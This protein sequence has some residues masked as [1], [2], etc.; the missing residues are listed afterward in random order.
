[1][2]LSPMLSPAGHPAL[3]GQGIG[4]AHT[5][6]AYR[7]MC[8]KESFLEH[9]GCETCLPPGLKR[10]PRGQ[11]PGWMKELGRGLTPHGRAPGP[12]P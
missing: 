7:R 12:C 10:K 9:G 8:A 5:L 3:E 1:M 6:C 4:W 11:T 2:P